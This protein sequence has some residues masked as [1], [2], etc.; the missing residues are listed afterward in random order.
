MADTNSAPRRLLT[1]LLVVLL[2]ACAG[3]VWLVWAQHE[4]RGF[5]SCPWGSGKGHPSLMG[6]GLALLCAGV[7]STTPSWAKTSRTAAIV[8]AVVTGILAG[9]VIL[10]VAFLFGA[11]LRCTD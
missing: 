5:D 10:V 1:A 3:A 11:S 7:A 9:A 6:L 2:P 8:L 4:Y